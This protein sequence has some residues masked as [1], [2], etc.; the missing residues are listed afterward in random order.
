VEYSYATKLKC[1]KCGAEY[2]LEY[3][4]VCK[5]CNNLVE[6]E[7]DLKQVAKL[8]FKEIHEKGIW[9]FH[10]VMPISSPDHTVTLGEGTTPL[11]VAERHGKNIGIERLAIK[12]EGSNPTGTFKD[13]S[14]ATAIAGALQFGFTKTAV[15]TT[16]NAGASIASYA[17]RAGIQSIVFCYSKAAPAK[18][19]H[20]DAAATQLVVFEGGYDEISVAVQKHVERLNIWDSDGRRNPWK[21]E[22]KKSLAYELFFDFGGE[23]PDF[24]LV[25]VSLGEMMVATW[26]GFREM[27]EMGWIDKIPRLVACQSAAANPVVR[28]WEERKAIVPQQV[29]YTIAEGVAVGAPGIKGDRA[30][31]AVRATE[32]LACSI[33]DAEI[34]E[35][36]GQLARAEGIWSGPTG[37]VTVACLAR[38]VK[39]KKIPGDASAVCVVS[40]T[41][42]KGDF[43]P[44]PSEQ[45]TLDPERIQR[46]LEK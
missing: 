42:L 40:E 22:G 41:G 34:V 38:L 2:P 11:I 10:P 3:M 19:Y 16:G 18:L 8:D 28:A 26:R 27:K 39:D 5:K 46:I 9:R 25:P 6:F 44:F 17:A 12:Y 13:R 31:E 14:S 43:P 7:Y 35:A 24:V 21:H 4:L 15:V 36:M 33:E 1:I 32:G 45:Q 23:L 37:A 30:L 29:G 20:L